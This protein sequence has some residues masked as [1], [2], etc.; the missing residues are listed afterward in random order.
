M[1][2]SPGENQGNYM[3]LK[4][5]P[6]SISFLMIPLVALAAIYGGWWIAVP[7]LWGWLA[8]GLLD[9]IIGLDTDNMDPKLRDDMLFWH[10]MVTWAWVPAQ[11]ALIV[12]VLWQAT[13]PGHLTTGESIGVALAL[14][15]ATGGI[16]IVYAHEMIHQRNR[17]EKWAGEFLLISTG[18]GHFATEHVFG[19]HIT[20]GTPADPVSARKGESL[21]AF[22]FRAI[23]GTLISAWKIDRKRLARR[24]RPVWHKSNPFWRYGLG[25][26]AFCLIAFALGGWWAVGLFAI[27][28]AMAIVQLEAVN[29]V[30]HYGLQRQ[31]I[32][33]G[34]FE[35]VG[36]HHSW[37][38]AHKV[39]NWLLI[40]LQRHSDHHFRP[41]RRF[42]L[43]QHYSWN[44]APQL[45]LS[46]AFMIGIATNPPLWFWIMNRRVDRWRAKFYPDVDDWSA[47]D[48]G[49]IGQE[50]VEA[51]A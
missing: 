3:L 51:A 29:Y 20:V 39:S 12:F 37:N 28:A 32:G 8:V 38:A 7:F 18:Y 14:G 41:D 4:A 13:R 19:H 47:Y 2:Y 45:P 22:M 1:A 48:R 42:P 11:F 10:K 33:N 30:E 31:Y 40:N 46:Y 6:F 23:P 35:R 43:L 9:K 16:G 24:E 34:R 15:A 36:P 25:V 21:Y 17:W 50:P 44:E 27:Q 26:L 5:L 49:T